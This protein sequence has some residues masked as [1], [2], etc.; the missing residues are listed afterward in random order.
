VIIIDDCWAL[1]G[2]STFRRRGFT[3]DGSSDLLCTDMQQV[4][5][6]SPTIRD[7]RRALMAARLGIPVD[8]EH[9]SCVQLND[10]QRSFQLVRQMLQ[11]G[12]LGYIDLPWR[13]FTPNAI[14]TPPFNNGSGK[15]RWRQFLLQPSC[16]HLSVRGKRKRLVTL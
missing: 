2:G 6:H 5:G 11:S 9:P 15:P 1:V 3:F 4:H 10:G 13:G 14:E 12:G 16:D 8:A 7:F